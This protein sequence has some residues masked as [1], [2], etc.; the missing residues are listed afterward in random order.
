MYL[1]VVIPTYNPNRERLLATIE[2]LKKQSAAPEA[3]ELILVDNNSN[4]KV[5][6]EI[7]LQW[8][9][10]ARAVIEKNQGLTYARLRGVDEAKGDIVIFV[11]DDNI[12][13]ESYVQ[14]TIAI[15]TDHPNIGAIGGKS[16]P[17][18]P[19]EEPEWLPTFYF[20]LALRDF[21]DEAIIQQWENKF[22]EYG[23]IG[24]GMAV[25]KA[26][27]QSY[28]AKITSG[29]S[30]ITDRKGNSLSSGGDN[31]ILLE[32]VKSGWDSGYFPQLSLRHIIPAERLEINYLG[33]LC[34]DLSK[35]WIYVLE[36]HGIS[37]WKKIP[38][39]TVPLRKLKSFVVYKAWKNS[40]NYLKWKG[41]CG[42]FEGL[43]G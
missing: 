31:D 36:S 29:K 8:K 12:L 14:N 39:W 32:I 15:F 1:S 30:I 27:L 17:E 9:A 19:Y 18:L 41:A 23:P 4:N 3:W 16:L 40:H 24:A 35:S 42:T 34:K 43:A 28:R 2:G 10:A 20:S 22:P 37:P 5:I 11:D 25:R 13:D 21:G 33:R 38:G 26:A 7:S 6:D